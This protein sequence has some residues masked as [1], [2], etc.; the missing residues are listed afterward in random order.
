M[1]SYMYLMDIVS[2]TSYRQGLSVSDYK[3]DLVPQ[4]F[5]ESQMLHLIQ[6]F[7]AP[8]YLLV[9]RLSQGYHLDLQLITQW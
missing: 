8:Q 5:Q 4:G 9:D 7:L 1:H 6:V 2:E 3:S